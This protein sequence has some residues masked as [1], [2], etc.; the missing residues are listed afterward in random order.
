MKLMN[1]SDFVRFEDFDRPLSTVGPSAPP[2]VQAL[3]L[4]ITAPSAH[5]TQPWKIKI[6]S[7]TEA[8]VYFD[9][10]R[11]LPFTDPPGRQVHISHGTLVEMTAIAGTSLGYQ[12]EVDILPQGEMTVAEFGTRPTAHIRMRPNAGVAVDPLFARIQHRRSSRKAHTGSPVTEKDL[13]QIRSHL[14]GDAVQLDLVGE[15]RFKAVLSIVERAMAIEVNERKLYGETL[16]WFRFNKN[17]IAEKGDGLN[18]YTSGLTGVPLMLA[19]LFVRPI[20]FHAKMNRASFLKSFNKIARSTRGLFTFVT[21]TNTMADWIRTGR[22]YVRAQLAADMLGLRFHPVCQS[23]QEFAEMDG[24]REELQDLLQVHAPA[25]IQMLV[26]VGRTETP[27]LSPRRK[28]VEIVSN[29][30]G[31]I[32]PM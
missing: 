22:A 9:P 30:D 10:E 1:S 4:G 27:A 24:T 12:T 31:R 16:T 6:Q 15:A 17:E 13:D 19:T 14:H 7:D 11:K 20:S 5:N 28:L 26:R 25:K 29:D 8:T 21:P 2:I 32:K 18:A 3:R 23:L